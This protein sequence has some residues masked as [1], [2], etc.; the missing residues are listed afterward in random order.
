MRNFFL[1]LYKKLSRTA[2]LDFPIVYSK[3]RVLF[4][5][6]FNPP[7][8]IV[9]NDIS[10]V[11][12]P[13]PKVA[14]SSSLKLICSHFNLNSHKSGLVCAV[15]NGLFLPLKNVVDKKCEYTFLVI[16]RDPVDRFISAFNDKL[17]INYSERI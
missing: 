15:E 7:S 17:V 8:C 2:D 14:T 12:L 5:K 4:R 1:K 10:T 6:I 13:I 9:L 16:C 11:Y 3:S